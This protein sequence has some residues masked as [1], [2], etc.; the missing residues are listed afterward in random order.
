M[1]LCRLSHSKRMPLVERRS[2][3][4][5]A[6]RVELRLTTWT[7]RTRI[8][9]RGITSAAPPRTKPLISVAMLALR[10]R[11]LTPDVPVVASV[12]LVGVLSSEPV[13]VMV[14]RSI[15]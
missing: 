9:R 5:R 6:Q 3:L 14:V 13:R 15:P 10:L 7:S 8:S 11:V 12:R 2:I 4:T 1:Q